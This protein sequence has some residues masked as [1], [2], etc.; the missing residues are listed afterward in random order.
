MKWTNQERETYSKTLTGIKG[1]K[2]GSKF[3][4]DDYTQGWGRDHLGWYACIKEVKVGHRY[5]SLW[6][7]L[8]WK[9]I[10]DAKKW[11]ERFRWGID[12]IKEETK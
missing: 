8:W 9:D 5:N 11:C 10:E 4:I 2:N 12:N 3:T 1:R 6:N 7:G